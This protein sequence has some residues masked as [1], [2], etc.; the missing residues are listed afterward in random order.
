MRAPLAKLQAPT[1]KI[2]VTPII[3]VALTLV[4]ILMMTMPM[5]SVADIDVEVPQA[6][7]RGMESQSR[8][9]LT[10][11]RAGELAIDDVVLTP[12]TF[13]AELHK[14]LQGIADETLVVVRAD[15]GVSYAEVATVL[16]QAR[17]A[18]AKR[19]AVAASPK[20]EAQ[21]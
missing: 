1:A 18:G 17:D 4:V 2:N 20:T 10:L 8:V 16:A 15:R 14:R 19:L 3:D 7:T 11:G 13:P 9:T 21:P 5:L 12:E 6:R